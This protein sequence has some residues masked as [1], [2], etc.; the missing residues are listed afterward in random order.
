MA[1]APQ[2]PTCQPAS[3]LMAGSTTRLKVTMLLTG[4]PGRPNTS[5]GVLHAAPHVLKSEYKYQQCSRQLLV[6]SQH[7]CGTL[8]LMH[9]E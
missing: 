4:L 2:L 7:A 5:R 8:H 6:G 9:C 3:F 1:A